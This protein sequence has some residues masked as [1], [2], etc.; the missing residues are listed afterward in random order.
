MA[1]VFVRLCV[2]VCVCIREAAADR[3]ALGDYGTGRGTITHRRPHRRP[4]TDSQAGLNADGSLIGI[5]HREP[6]KSIY[7]KGGGGGG[8]GGKGI[9]SFSHS[10]KQAHYQ[11]TARTSFFYSTYDSSFSYHAG[12][13]HLFFLFLLKNM[14]PKGQK[15]LFAFLSNKA[16]LS[17]QTDHRVG[18][19]CCGC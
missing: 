9:A 11:A 15:R 4:Q 5:C 7:L 2:F 12:R 18:D 10:N 6:T 3:Q 13:D 8:P 14:F 16:A 1:C 17:L 19:V